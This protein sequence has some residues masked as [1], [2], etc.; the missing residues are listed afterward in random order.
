[1]GTIAIPGTRAL[2]SGIATN[3]R[4]TAGTFVPGELVWAGTGMTVAEFPADTAGKIV[5]MENATTNANRNIQVG[6][7]ADLG[8]AGV[9]LWRT[10][11]TPF[12][13]ALT[14]VRTIP[15]LGVGGGQGTILKDR[16]DAGPVTVSVDTTSYTGLTA[17]NVHA[18]KAPTVGD[19]ENA[20]IVMVS[21]HYDSVRGAPGA[22]DDGSGTMLTLEL[23]RVFKDLKS[24]K[25]LRFSFWGAEE[26][27][28]IGSNYYVNNAPQAELDRF[29]GVWQND[30]V[31]TSWEPANRYNLLT[32][33]GLHNT[34]TQ[35]VAAVAP[36]L[37]HEAFILGPV[38]RGGSDHVPFHNRGIAA[39]NHSWRPASGPGNL[40]PAYHTP[41]D[42]IE[43]NLS[44]ERWRVSMELIGSA[45]YTQA[46]TAEDGFDL[47]SDAVADLELDASQWKLVRFLDRIEREMAVDDTEEAC[48]ATAAYG[49]EVD[50]LAGLRPERGPLDPEVAYDLRAFTQNLSLT[51]G[52]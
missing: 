48:R 40:E 14:T 39:A 4:I 6:N 2:Q 38:V 23:A 5:L 17:Y 8:A 27:G 36:R 25:E 46:Q 50:R 1:M 12:D 22:N 11:A 7:A 24:D 41:E 37:G 52:C 43:N 20:P 28:L 42:T 10:Q 45:I 21:G 15:V 30:M 13:P 32:V 34:V 16:I 9:I 51:L 47:L 33:H 3:G 19:A 18:S 44:P 49:E 29:V 26:Q 31:A 35:A